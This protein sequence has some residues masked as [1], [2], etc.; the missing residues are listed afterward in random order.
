MPYLLSRQIYLEYAHSFVTHCCTYVHQIFFH[1]FL[2]SLISE[3][4]M[5]HIPMW[6]K[7]VYTT[8][9]M[10]WRT[11][12]LHMQLILYIYKWWHT[13]F[14]PHKEEHWTYLCSRKSLRIIL[15]INVVDFVLSYVTIIKRRLEHMHTLRRKFIMLYIN[16]ANSVF[17]CLFLIKRHLNCSVRAFRE[18]IY[19]FSIGY[20]TIF[21]IVYSQ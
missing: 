2:A 9:H 12:R 14:L 6:T 7:H 19:R 4:Q 8:P 17:C 5:W 16:V 10:F 21:F 3:K 1:D 13:L 15:Y 11:T 20:E 18:S